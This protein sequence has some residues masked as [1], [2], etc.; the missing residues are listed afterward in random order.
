MLPVVIASP[1]EMFAVVSDPAKDK[2]VL[3]FIV[4]YAAEAIPDPLT[5]IFPVPTLLKTFTF[6]VVC[7]AVIILRFPVVIASPKMIVP[8]M[9]LLPIL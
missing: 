7:E 5:I 2:P 9:I 4:S 3:E 8:S 1:I 6:P